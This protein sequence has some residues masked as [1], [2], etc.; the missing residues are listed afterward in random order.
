[1]LQTLWI[2]EQLSWSFLAYAALGGVCFLE[3]SNPFGP[4][5]PGVSAILVAGYACGSE[6]ASTLISL[7]TIVISIVLA[8]VLNSILG[9]LLGARLAKKPSNLRWIERGT[10]VLKRKHPSILLFQFSPILRGA[11]PF[12]FGMTRLS[13]KSAFLVSFSGSLL[14]ASAFLAIGFIAAR[15]GSSM[16]SA[17]RVATLIQVLLATS[18]VIGITKFFLASRR[19][20]RPQ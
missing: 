4:V 9:G 5:F 2:S 12:V 6:E 7:S 18:T 13:R 17:V 19:S 1:V 3:H 16:G 10:I 11:L 8:N 15:L 20:N 14:F